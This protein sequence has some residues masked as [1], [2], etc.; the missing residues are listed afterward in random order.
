[1]ELL[2]YGYNHVIQLITPVFKALPSH[3]STVW[4]LPEVR[5]IVTDSISRFMSSLSN[6]FPYTLRTSTVIYNVSL[7]DPPRPRKT[8]H[9]TGRLRERLA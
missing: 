3:E 6:R 5:H 4:N 8:R 7:S 2:D 1:V 9:A